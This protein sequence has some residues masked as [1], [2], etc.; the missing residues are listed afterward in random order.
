MTTVAVYVLS[1]LLFAVCRTDR[2]TLID[3]YQYDDS[4]TNDTFQREPYCVKFHLQ[5]I[6]ACQLD[7]H[8]EP[9]GRS[10]DCCRAP[11]TWHD[12]VSVLLQYYFTLLGEVRSIV[13]C[14]EY[15]QGV[16]SPLK[17]FAVF[18]AT[19]WNFN[20]KFYKYIFKCST[21]NCQVKRDSVEKRPSY[22]LRWLASCFYT[23]GFMM[24]YVYS[25]VVRA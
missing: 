14:D 20:L 4:F 22:R 24:Q 16:A 17:F 13:N 11:S 6:G 5:H 18:S 21:S 1:V 8:V 15:I 19:V 9:L 12:V 2:V 23:V 25:Y 10:G 7:H 3:T